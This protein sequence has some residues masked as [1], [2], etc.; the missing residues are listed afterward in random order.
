MAED[1]ASGL[2]EE[3]IAERAAE[4]Q[5]SELERVTE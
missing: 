3:S 2:S 4:A 1:M 5:A